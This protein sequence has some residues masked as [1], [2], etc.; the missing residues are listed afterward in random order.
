MGVWTELKNFLL[1]FVRQGAVELRSC[2]LSEL[3]G[4]IGLDLVRISWSEQIFED[5]GDVEGVTEQE[6]LRKNHVLVVAVVWWE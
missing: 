1:D 5:Q 2:L 3:I 4:G 6:Y